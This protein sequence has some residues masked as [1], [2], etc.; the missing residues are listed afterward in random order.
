MKKIF[1][2]TLLLFFILFSLL[3]KQETS[4]SIGINYE[5][6]EYKIPVYV[7]LFD[8]MQRHFN[9]KY[10]VYDI[11]KWKYQIKFKYID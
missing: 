2:T 8:F 10:I 3:M 5:I 11:F 9:Y 4:R 6:Y 1:F 7:K